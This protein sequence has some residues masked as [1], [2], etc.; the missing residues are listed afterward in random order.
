MR[1]DNVREMS[2]IF[3]HFENKRRDILLPIGLVPELPFKPVT[4]AG[5]K[6][7]TFDF[8]EKEASG[9]PI[10]GLFM[11]NVVH[12]LRK[13]Y[14]GLLFKTDP[15]FCLLPGKTFAADDCAMALL[16]FG[17][18]PVMVVEYK[19]KV[20][21]NIRDITPTWHL[22]ELFIQAFYLRKYN[23]HPILHCLTDLQDYHFFLV[24]Q[25]AADDVVRKVDVEKY[26]Y[27]QCDLSNQ[28]EYNRVFNFL[29]K[30]LNVN[31]ALPHC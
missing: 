20:P 23:S 11:N 14:P 5:L 21:G 25:Q 10:V 13:K 17:N 1:I 19:P 28:D 3:D 2:N 22:S 31:V 4:F 12:L 15:E 24:A 9:R 6:F 26:W 27:L 7:D 16:V 30:E 8:G 18:F 29:Q